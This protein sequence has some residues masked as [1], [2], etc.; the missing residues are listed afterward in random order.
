MYVVDE[1]YALYN[2]TCPKARKEHT[3]SACGET[4]APRQRYYRVALVFDGSASTVK[5]CARCQK[6]HEHLRDLGSDSWPDERLNCGHDYEDMHDVPPPPEIAALA[7][8]LPGE[9]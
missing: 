1:Y 3:C 8:A 4:I 6:I 7:F 9:V 5:R 2:E